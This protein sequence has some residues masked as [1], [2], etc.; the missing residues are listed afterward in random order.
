MSQVRCLV[1]T[2]SA[3]LMIRR[4]IIF[5]KMPTMMPLLGGM[6][7]TVGGVNLDAG[8]AVTF[9]YSAAMVQPGRQV[10]LHLT[11]QSMA[12]QV[13]VKVLWLSPPIHQTL[14][15][16]VLEMRHPVPVYVV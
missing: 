12:V 8:E 16:S 10:M 3:I 6:D 4:T 11:L 7:V 14:R 5:L 9:V 2:I 15:Q 1:V 13:P